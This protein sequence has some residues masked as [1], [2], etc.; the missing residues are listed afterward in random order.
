VLIVVLHASGSEINQEFGNRV[1]RNSNHPRSRTDA[2]A[3]DQ[4][5]Y[6]LDLVVF[7]EAIHTE[8]LCL[9]SAKSVK[10]FVQF[11]GGIVINFTVDERIPLGVV[12][13]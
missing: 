8:Q 6:D 13:V 9:S 7:R 3:L 10:H 2:V 5:C 11:N 1:A 4:S 12:I